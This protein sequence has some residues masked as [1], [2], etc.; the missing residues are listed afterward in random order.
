MIRV[1]AIDQ[2]HAEKFGMLV[3]QDNGGRM[4]PFSTTS[5]EVLRK[6]SRKSSLYGL[7]AN[8]I[9]LGMAQNPYLWQLAPIIKVNNEELQKKLGIE[10][11]YT[12]FF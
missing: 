3:V 6:V 5:S 4:K 10:G 7:N 8:Q 11:K 9:V 12:S 2:A 1:S